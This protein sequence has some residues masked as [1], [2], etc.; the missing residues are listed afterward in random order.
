VRDLAVARRRQAEAELGL[1][2]LVELLADLWAEDAIRG[3]PLTPEDQPAQDDGGESG[4]A[5]RGHV[6][7]APD[8]QRGKDTRG[9][10]GE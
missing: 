6:T 4:T 10:P 8:P 7:A 9:L 5:G 3:R 1:D 2:A